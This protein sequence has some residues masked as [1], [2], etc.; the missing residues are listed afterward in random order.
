MSFGFVIDRGAFASQHPYTRYLIIHT[1]NVPFNLL[2]AHTINTQQM[3]ART[4][5]GHVTD[6]RNDLMKFRQ[7]FFTLNGTNHNPNS[8]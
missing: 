3:A 2:Q 6:T 7:N 5:L 8:L 1:T 4:I